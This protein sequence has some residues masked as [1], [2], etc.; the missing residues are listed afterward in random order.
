M[1]AHASQKD[2]AQGFGGKYGVQT[3][4]KDKSAAGWEDRE[5][6]Q[7]HESQKGAQNA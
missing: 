5:Q 3:D 6:L 1:D 2:Y 7:Q 4:R